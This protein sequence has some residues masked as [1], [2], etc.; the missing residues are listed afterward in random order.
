[1]LDATV[2]VNGVSVGTVA[3]GGT[4]YQLIQDDA[5]AS[6]GTS[7]NPSIVADCVVNNDASSPTWTQNIQPEQTFSL[8]QAK[9]LDSDGSTT[10]LADYKP[11]TDGFMFT[12]TQCRGGWQRP[13]EWRTMPTTVDG[14]AVTYLLWAVWED[15]PNY[16]AMRAT[17]SS[18]NY[19]V[20]L[21]NDGTAVTNHASNVVSEFDL[22]YTKGTDEFAARGYKQVIIKITGNITTLDFNRRH[23]DE[24]TAY[25][26]GLLS[27]KITSQAITSL[28]NLCRAQNVYHRI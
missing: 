4:F 1:M 17:T 3:S 16:F 22:D 12:A 27:L 14:D 2:E 13:S 24:S 7:A 20:D 25:N 23:S 5:G 11:N 6:V 15:Q 9:M 10:V 28:A 8:A 26:T 18:G 21:Y 19:T